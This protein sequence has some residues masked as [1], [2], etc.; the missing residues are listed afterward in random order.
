[1]EVKD[2]V[3]IIITWICVPLFYRIAKKLTHYDTWFVYLYK[4]WVILLGII[5]TLYV[6]VSA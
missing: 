5:F 1:M 6:V 2:V 3:A 4:Y